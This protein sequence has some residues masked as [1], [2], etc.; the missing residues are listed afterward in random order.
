[1]SWKS[2]IAL[3][4]KLALPTTPFYHTP[5]II[6]IENILRRLINHKAPISKRVLDKY[7]SDS[8]CHTMNGPG[9]IR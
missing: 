1:M 3:S 6:C 2:R 5:L 4:P 9:L 7:K 8:F